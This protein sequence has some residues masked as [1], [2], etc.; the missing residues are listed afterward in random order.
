MKEHATKYDEHPMKLVRNE[1]A[2]LPRDAGLTG[3]PG[4]VRK[5][6]S[7]CGKDVLP[8]YILDQIDARW[9]QVVTTVTGYKTY[10]EFRNGINKEL[11]RNF[12]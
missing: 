5:G 9:N 4:K 2:G 12:E 8:Q 6:V 10:E 1:A 7:N 11:K 3:N